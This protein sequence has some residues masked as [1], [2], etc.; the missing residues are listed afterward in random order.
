MLFNLYRG[1]L[2][3]WFKIPQFYRFILVG[4]Y[5]TV[6]SG[7]CFLCLHFALKH[8]LHYLFILVIS[9]FLTVTNSFFTFKFFVFTQSTGKMWAEYLKTHISYLLYIF[10]NIGLL[11][12]TVECLKFDVR[13]AQLTIMCVLSILFYFVHKHFSFY[14]KTS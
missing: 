10:C 4:G 9:H 3:F 1:V 11:Y 8:V 13:K 7:V 12:I 2:K 6:F 5:N 14:E